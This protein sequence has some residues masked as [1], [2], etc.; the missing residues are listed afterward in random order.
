MSPLNYWRPESLAPP[1][2]S[3]KTAFS[4]TQVLSQQSQA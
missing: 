3:Y 2:R 4:G 1:R